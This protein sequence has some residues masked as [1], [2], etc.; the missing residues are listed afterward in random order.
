MARLVAI[1]S[2]RH[3]PWIRSRWEQTSIR[4]RAPY[5]KIWPIAVCYVLHSD[6]LRGSRGYSVAY[7]DAAPVSL[8]MLA[9]YT[10]LIV[11]DSGFENDAWVIGHF[12]VRFSS[13]RNDRVEHPF[14]RRPCCIHLTFFALPRFLRPWPYIA[15]FSP[16]EICHQIPLLRWLV[17]GLWQ[18]SNYLR[19]ERPKSTVSR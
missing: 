3:T 14:Y 19:A 5:I 11:E 10:G 17:S 2:L 1:M 9:L 8:G 13:H 12:H 6:L 16:S 15:A 7:G 18:I 4:L